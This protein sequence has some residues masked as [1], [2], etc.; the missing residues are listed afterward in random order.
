MIAECMD[1]PLF[2]RETTMKAKLKTMSY[3]ETEGDEVED[4]FELI[5]KAKESCPEITAVAS[6]AI[7]SD[8]QRIRVENVCT[9]LGLVSLSYLWRRDQSELLEEMR[10]ANINAIIIKIASLGLTAKRH[11]GR[12]VTDLSSNL[13][14]MKDKFGLNVCGEGGEYETLT[15]DCDLYKKRIV[16]D[17]AHVES[18]QDDGIT[19]VALYIIDKC[20]C[21][22]K[23][24]SQT[25]H[26]ITLDLQDS[27]QL[28]K[29]LFWLLQNTRR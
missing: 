8:Y 25:E 11:L 23:V 9:R 22:P 27:D 24:T 13:H 18:I 16:I 5:K 2:R 4:L 7:F 15:L 1:L 29:M 26:K 3:K 10:L 17:N 21:E 19:E 12:S 14:S 20:H 28:P 6:G